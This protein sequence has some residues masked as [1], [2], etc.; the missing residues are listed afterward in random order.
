MKDEIFRE[1]LTTL[2]LILIPFPLL[3]PA[4][5]TALSTYVLILNS[6]GTDVSL[7][8]KVSNEPALFVNEKVEFLIAPAVPSKIAILP[9]VTVPV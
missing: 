5:L 4:L 6:D 8:P 2:L 7:A 3:K 1:T 9:L